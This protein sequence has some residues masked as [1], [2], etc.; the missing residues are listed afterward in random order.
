MRANKRWVIIGSASAVFVVIG[1]S[2]VIW[3]LT[4]IVHPDKKKPGATALITLVRGSSG[5][6]INFKSLND[7]I[8]QAEAGDRILVGAVD[9][10]PP[11]LEDRLMAVGGG[12]YE[13]KSGQKVQ[14]KNITIEADPD[15]KAPVRWLPRPNQDPDNSLITISQFEGLKLRGFHIDGRGKLGDLIL[16]NGRCPGLILEDFRLAG[17][18]L[19][20]V[21]FVNGSGDRERPM[22]LEKVVFDGGQDSQAAAAIVFGLNQ[23]QEVPINTGQQQQNNQPPP[24]N[25]AQPVENVKVHDCLIVGPLRAGVNF[26]DSVNNIVLAQN[27]FY[28]LNSAF[29]FNKAF[30]LRR[31]NVTLEGSTI[32][33][34]KSG[35]FHFEMLPPADDENQLRIQNNLFLKAERLVV[36]DN[37]ASEPAGVRAKWIWLNEGDPVRTAPV[38]DCLF[39]KTFQL[40]GK[41]KRA[42]IDVVCDDAFEAYVNGSLIGQG[43]FTLQKSKVRAFEV[44]DK[45]NSGKNVIAI[46]G[47]NRDGP[48]GLMARLRVIGMDGGQTTIATD[49]SWR[50]TKQANDVWH[51]VEFDDNAWPRPR[52][53]ADY[54]GG[55]EKWRNLHWDCVEQEQFRDLYPVF[56]QALPGNV[57]DSATTDGTV[58]LDVPIN[59]GGTLSVDRN[60]P[61]FLRYPKDSPLATAGADKKP[62]GYPPY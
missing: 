16:V 18:T 24:A 56:V 14:R 21:R 51:T 62:V 25:P 33:N 54:G 22:T 1:L 45:L 15:L 39:R 17:F 26:R 35:A 6:R 20:G 2:L 49:D 41:S 28:N 32:Y 30:P 10:Q 44:T 34:M 38:G 52:V 53:L 43:D 11:V 37:K 42:V 58:K 12:E 47:K 55:N 48:A 60:N 61:N 3:K 5:E 31:A 13:N 9:G 27:R 36:S 57:R 4:S 19:A 40:P 46:K 23:I 50:V 8:T 29:T 59:N 7:A